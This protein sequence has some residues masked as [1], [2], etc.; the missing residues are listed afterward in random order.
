M[1]EQNPSAFENMFD[2]RWFVNMARSAMILATVVGLPV[3]GYAMKRLVDKA[4]TIV[5]T[6]AKTDKR[7]DLL[8]QFVRFT[9][10]QTQGNSQRNRD[11][12]ADH[13]GR[14]RSLERIGKP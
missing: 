10:E 8:E 1:S 2:A 14:I 12:I 4:D 7:L 3:A 9:T 11:T 5:D 6:V 13:E